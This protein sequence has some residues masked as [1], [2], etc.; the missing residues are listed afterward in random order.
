MFR[1]LCAGCALLL[2]G[3]GLELLGAAAIQSDLQARQMQGMKRHLENAQEFSAETTITQAIRVYQAEKGKNP[4][5]LEAL[6]P[7][8]LPSVPPKPDGSPYGYDPATGTLLEAPLV[9]AN[10]TPDDYRSLDRIRAAIHQYGQATGWYPATLGDLVPTYLAEYPLTSDGREFL[11]DAP[12]GQAAHPDQAAPQPAAVQPR[13]VDGVSQPLQNLNQAGANAAG[14]RSRGD[15][16]Q[17]SG[18]YGD[19]QMQQMDNL[20]L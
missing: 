14:T 11:Y 1:V 17:I 18:A 5:S 16:N 20:G 19:N 2:S 4:P 3:C 9:K 10:I 13:A 7:E 12:S 8:Y 15:V 6:V